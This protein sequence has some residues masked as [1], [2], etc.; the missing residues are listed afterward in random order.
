[1]KKMYLFI[2]ILLITLDIFALAPLEK[3]DK[4]PNFSAI[5]ENGDTWELSDQRADYLV[6]YFYPAAFTGGCTKQACSYRDHEAA[7]NILNAKVVG[8]SG[9]DHENLK[10]FKAF[11]NLN[12]TLLSD[13]D[14]KIAEIFGVP[15]RDGATIE[16]EVDGKT[17]QLTREVTT[18]RWTYVV[19]GNGRLL[20]KDDDV[21]AATDP[22]TVLKALTT[23]NERK[24]CVQR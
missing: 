20:Y 24:S 4:V 23:H 6:I 9:D 1:M 15:I 19:D 12:F 14:G 13:A 16:K 18:S 10:A 8:V 2:P 21:Q 3:G 5:D 22:E 17:L 11:L 7:F